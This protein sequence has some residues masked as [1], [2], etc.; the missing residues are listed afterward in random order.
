MP[1]TRA[2]SSN[3]M[4]PNSSPSSSTAPSAMA[5]REAAANLRQFSSSRLQLLD[6]LFE[7]GD[8]LAG[9]A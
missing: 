9:V 4:M 5:K 2:S 6:M 7:T 8:V 3:G 1:P